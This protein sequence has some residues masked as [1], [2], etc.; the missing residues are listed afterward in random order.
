MPAHSTCW[1]LQNW[2]LSSVHLSTLQHSVQE[3]V[4]LET[5]GPWAM[6]PAQLMQKLLRR[7]STSHFSCGQLQT[8]GFEKILTESLRDELEMIKGVRITMICSGRI[9]MVRSMTLIIVYQSGICSEM[10]SEKNTLTLDT[11]GLPACDLLYFHSKKLLDDLFSVG[12]HPNG[13]CTPCLS[14]WLV[15]DQLDDVI[16]GDQNALLIQVKPFWKSTGRNIK[17]Q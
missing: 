17:S 2:E 4:Q 9:T 5:A 3:L 15:I 14:I 16:C 10:I 13:N 8:T 7:P 6:G 11:F 1:L 12:H